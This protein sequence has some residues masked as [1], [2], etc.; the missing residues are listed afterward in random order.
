MNQ[1]RKELNL[2]GISKFDKYLIL[3][4]AL[5]ISL[6]RPALPRPVHF[7]LVASLCMFALLPLMPLRTMVIPIV[8][9]GGV[10]FALLLQSIKFPIFSRK[11]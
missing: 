5:W 1:K 8:I 2:Q 11:E 4:Y 3:F 7:S 6:R 10:S 9:G